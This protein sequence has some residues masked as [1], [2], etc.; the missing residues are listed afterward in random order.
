M[1]EWKKYEGTD[2]QIAEM[3]NAEHGFVVKTEFP[4]IFNHV[5]N[6]S[7]IKGLFYTIKTNLACNRA[8]HYL[9]CDPHPL[10]DMIKRWAETGQPV[11]V[12]GSTYDPLT[13]ER[14][15]SEPYETTMPDWN[16]PG[17]EY[18]FTPFGEEK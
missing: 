11:W 3:L 15:F 8:T 12:K 10:A 5:V 6:T 1:S 7:N 14:F 2:E 9:T 17:A 16:I 18:S 13:A 4:S